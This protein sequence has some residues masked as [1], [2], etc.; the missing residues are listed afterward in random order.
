MGLTVAT[1]LGT[2]SLGSAP[3]SAAGPDLRELVLGSEGAFGVITSVTVRVRPAPAVRV[4]DGWRFESF[5]E[6]SAAL[7]QLA[8][9]GVAPTVLRLSDENETA[10]NLAQPDDVGGESS[11]GGL[12]VAGFEGDAEAVAARR[13]VVTRRLAAAGGSAAG[14]G[15]GSGLGRG[16]VPRAVPPGRDARRRGARRDAGDRDVLVRTARAVRRGDGRR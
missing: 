9:A 7:R 13:D 11:G 4:Y 3:A 16:T 10:I 8:Q 14:R 6:G 1:P 15:A 5:A 12:M 2:L